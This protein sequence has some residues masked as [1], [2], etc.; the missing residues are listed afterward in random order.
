M[1]SKKGE[2]AANPIFWCN[3]S[4]IQSPMYRNW[5]LG[6]ALG[7]FI[8]NIKA[9]L[10]QARDGQMLLQLFKGLLSERG[11]H[12]PQ[13]AAAAVSRQ[14]LHRRICHQSAHMLQGTPA[15]VAVVKSREVQ[16]S[17]SDGKTIPDMSAS[18]ME[19]NGDVDLLVATADGILYEYAVSDSRGSSPWKSRLER[20]SVITGS[21]SDTSA[22]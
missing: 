18:E 12:M 16:A 14:D 9:C 10:D 7:M 1:Q 2:C 3:K 8:A 22:R 13:T 20:E 17:S 5:R 21:S 15:V 11:H 19:D 4:E 6:K